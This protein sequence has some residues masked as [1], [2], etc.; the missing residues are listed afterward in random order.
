MLVMAAALYVLGKAIQ[1]F[2]GDDILGGLLNAV[3]A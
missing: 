3:I 1:L 2:T